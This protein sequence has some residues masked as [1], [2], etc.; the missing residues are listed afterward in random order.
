LKQKFLAIHA[1][2]EDLHNTMPQSTSLL[3]VLPNP[4]GI[5][6]EKDPMSTLLFKQLNYTARNQYRLQ[7]MKLQLPLSSNVAQIDSDF[8]TILLDFDVNRKQAKLLPKILEL[9]H[10]RRHWVVDE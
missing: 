10:P 3:Q 9:F 5:L 6:C 2:P 1:A 8:I 4:L 7:F